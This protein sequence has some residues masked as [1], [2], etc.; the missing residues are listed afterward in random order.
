M[1]TDERMLSLLPIAKTQL[2]N[3]K[4]YIQIKELTAIKNDFYFYDFPRVATM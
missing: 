2:L 4:K 3:L 1:N